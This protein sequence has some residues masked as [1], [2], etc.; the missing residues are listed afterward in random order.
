[1][2]AAAF[3]PLPMVAQMAH[4]IGCVLA[5]CAVLVF[6]VFAVGLGLPPLPDLNT[7]FAAIGVMLLGFVLMW[8][9]DWLGGVVSLL[10]LG[11]FQAMEVAANGHVA[12]RLFPLLVIPGALGII[13][14]LARCYARS[15]ATSPDRA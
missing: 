15:A 9:K 8:W 13:A 1:M 7:S 4:W 3:K 12:G 11:W 5:T 14:A 6:V 10:G 2:S